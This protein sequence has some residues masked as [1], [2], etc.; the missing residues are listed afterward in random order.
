VGVYLLT[1]PFNGKYLVYY[2][3][4]TGASFSKRMLQNVQSYLNG[5][6]RVFEPTEF[7]QAK[8]SLIWGG[9]WK[10]DRKDLKLIGE[11]LKQ[12]PTLSPKIVQFVEQFRIFLA[13]IDCDKRLRERIESAIA[14]KLSVKEGVVS[15]FQDKDIRYRPIMK[16]KRPSR[17]HSLIFL[18]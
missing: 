13:P 9:M 3:G 4:E 2:V 15:D 1:I 6:Y 8:K 5:F 10:T 16:A 18:R 12:Q 17:R 11:F 7:S 14:E